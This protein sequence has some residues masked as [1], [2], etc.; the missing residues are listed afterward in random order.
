MFT[1]IQTRIDGSQLVALLVLA[2]LVAGCSSSSS[3][4]APVAKPAGPT[5]AGRLQAALDQAVS[6]GLPGAALAV[7]GDDFSFDGVAGVEDI[8]TA[9][10]LTRNHRFY[11]GSIGKTYTA[12]A[13]IRLAADGLLSLDDP[14]TR[15]LPA[16]IGDRIPGGD[17]ISIRSLLNH[18]SGIVDFRADEWDAAFIE[19]P[20]IH[21]ANS[22][23]LPLFLDKPLGF[24]PTTDYAYSNSNYVLAALIAEQ[25]SG[26][27]MQ[28]LVRNYII[29][30]LGLQDTA[31]GY[32]AQGL[33]NFAHGYLD[34]F[35]DIIDTAPWY[36]HYGIADGGMQSSAADL[37]AFVRQVLNGDSVLN[38][39]QRAEFLKP[40]GAGNPP[41]IYGL[42]IEIIAGKNPESYIYQHAGK[43]EGYQALFIHMATPTESLTVSLCVS[44][45]VGDYDILYEQLNGAVMDIL[46]DV[47]LLPGV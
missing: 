21:W 7:R 38:D 35:G 33:A 4:V 31:H 29:A 32:E 37:A 40:S 27:A 20:T 5:V 42:G 46:A 24:L 44:A 39:P 3:P 36:N 47:E 10:P 11:L 6:G 43:N 34:G 45:S 25:A 12:V 16:A 19:D 23:V 9:V 13:T 22:D 28:D 1:K 41:S 30:P 26:L 15:W 14:I 17:A 2:I 18:T 8:A